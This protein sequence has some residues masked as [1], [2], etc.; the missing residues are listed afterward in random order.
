[1]NLIQYKMISKILLL[2]YK[3]GMNHRLINIVPRAA[4][5]RPTKVLNKVLLPPPFGPTTP[6][7][8]PLGILKETSSNAK[9]SS[10]STHKLETSIEYSDEDEQHEGRQSYSGELEQQVLLSALILV[11]MVA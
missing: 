1:M 8:T 11:F 3:L 2:L 4:D 9:T 10:N 7:S 5:W 6:V